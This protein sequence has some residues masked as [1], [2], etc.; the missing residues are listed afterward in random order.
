MSTFKSFA[1]QIA[2]MSVGFYANYSPADQRLAL[3][4]ILPEAT[5]WPQR[6]FARRPEDKGTFVLPV[7]QTLIKNARLMPGTRCMLML[8]AG[9]AGKAYDNRRDPDDKDTRVVAARSISTTRGIIGKHLG[10]SARQVARYLN[11]AKREGLLEWSYVVNR[12]TGMITGLKITLLASEIFGGMKDRQRYLD[13]KAENRRKS[14]ATVK[15][16]TNQKRF[17]PSTECDE[18]DKFIARIEKEHGWDLKKMV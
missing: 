6:C 11:D 7:K 5:T 16:D 2:R 17:K 8:L 3:T 4:S 15:A 10:R 12:L 9:W 1:G 13:E 18:Y 14:D